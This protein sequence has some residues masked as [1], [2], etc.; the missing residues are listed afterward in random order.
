MYI[1]TIFVLLAI[2]GTLYGREAT[3][4][5]SLFIA[6][7]VF[8]TSFAARSLDAATC[9]VVPFGTHF[10]WHLL[11]ALLLYLLARAVISNGRAGYQ[12]RS[13]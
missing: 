3:A 11:N 13:R 9:S 5:K 7:G 2:A 8:V 1:P 6:T 12:M 4:S 10:A